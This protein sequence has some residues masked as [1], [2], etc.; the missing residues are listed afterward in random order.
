MICTLTLLLTVG[1]TG[2]SLTRMS[3]NL[4]WLCLFAALLAWRV[5]DDIAA[6][7]RSMAH[8]VGAATIA[9]IVVLACIQGYNSY[10]RMAGRYEPAMRYFWPR[11]T[12]MGM[13]V[14]SLPPESTVYVLHSYGRETLT[15]LIGDREDVHLV[16]DPLSLDLDAIVKVPG[17]VFFVVEYSEYS[18]ALAE[19]LVYLINRFGPQG[20]KEFADRR[21]G[22]DRKIF[23]SYEL[24]KDASGQPIPPP[25]SMP[26]APPGMS[27]P[28]PIDPPPRP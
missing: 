20:V 18:R 12:I 25:D 26:D 8:W 5:Y 6:R 22:P 23:Y 24:W 19:V 3:L 17:T 4:P 1:W 9:G 2:P 11:Q 21:F 16:T 13:F 15:Y 14:R 27:F 28:A 7:G 10:F